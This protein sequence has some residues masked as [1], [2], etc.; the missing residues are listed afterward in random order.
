MKVVKFL[1]IRSLGGKA[2]TRFP[3]RLLRK[4][5]ILRNFAIYVFYCMVELKL[6]LF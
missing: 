4:I 6:D 3:E 5:G 1:K 2:K